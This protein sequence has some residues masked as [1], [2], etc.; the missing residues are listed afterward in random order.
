MEHE[1]E[2]IEYPIGRVLYRAPLS[3]GY[4]EALRVSPRGD[5]VAFLDHPLH[6]DSAGWVATVDLAGHYRTISSHF[7]STRGL[8]WSPNGAE[9]WF[10]A[11]KQGTNM[12]VWAVNRSGRERLVA[13]FPAYISV[14]DISTDRRV[15]VP[16]AMS[17]SVTRSRRPARSPRPGGLRTWPAGSAP[18]SG[19]SPGW[20]EAPRCRRSRPAAR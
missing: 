19:S 16:V 17:S 14:E 11:A 6:D 18:R 8:A 5:A 7:N 15:L 20:P 13:R 2:Q 3:S 10:A 9:V 4:M 12:A 1:R